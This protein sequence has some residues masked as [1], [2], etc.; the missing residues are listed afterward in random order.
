MKSTGDTRFAELATPNGM[1]A[2]PGALCV[3]AGVDIL[4]MAVP[5][6]MMR[7]GGSRR[8]SDGRATV[9]HRV[10]PPVL[11]ECGGERRR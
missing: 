11:V 1:V 2:G 9:I 7:G 5:Q 3:Q 8:G 6:P 10:H 4:E